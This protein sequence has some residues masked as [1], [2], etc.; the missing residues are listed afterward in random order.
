MVEID[1]ENAGVLSELRERRREL[2]GQDPTGVAERA[3]RFEALAAV[4]RSEADWWAGVAPSG[5]LTVSV[6][7]A[8]WSAFCSAQSYAAEKAEQ[9]SG[10]AEYWQQQLVVRGPS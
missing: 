3:A 5:S 6:R 4:Y 10:Y 9:Y 1:E 8:V 7:A 2:F